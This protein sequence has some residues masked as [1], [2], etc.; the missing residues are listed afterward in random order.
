MDDQVE[1]GRSV[2]ETPIELDFRAKHLS[3]IPLSI[4]WESSV[5]LEAL[6]AVTVRKPKGR[7]RQYQPFAAGLTKISRYLFGEYF[8]FLLAV[9]QN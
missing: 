9:A 2:E 6:S 8:R 1:L 7:E 5:N 4:A 3:S